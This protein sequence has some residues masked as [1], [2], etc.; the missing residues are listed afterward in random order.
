MQKL[1]EAGKIH[2]IPVILEPPGNVRASRKFTTRNGGTSIVFRG[3]INP[4]KTIN[5]L[6]KQEQLCDILNHMYQRG[7]LTM[8]NIEQIVR[9]LLVVL[10]EKRR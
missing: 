1:E 8:K 5:K 7:E 2:S 3:S 6:L 9:V 10:N 4:A